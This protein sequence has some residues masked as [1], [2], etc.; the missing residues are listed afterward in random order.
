VVLRGEERPGGVEIAGLHVELGSLGEAVLIAADLGSVRSLTGFQVVANRRVGK[1]ALSAELRRLEG[2]S[3]AGHAR[4]LLLELPGQPFGRRHHVG[5]RCTGATLGPLLL[6]HGSLALAAAARR[7]GDPHQT[8]TGDGGHGS[9]DGFLEGVEMCRDP[10]P[11]GY[12]AN[13]RLEG[14]VDAELR[15]EGTQQ[16]VRPHQQ[17]RRWRPG[18]R[19][20]WARGVRTEWADPWAAY[21]QTGGGM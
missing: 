16:P 3:L 4:R 6:V 21:R 15:C 12:D 5:G 7:D 8:E 10:E 18:E 14:L 2:L 13:P 9:R 17:R 20:W 19:S 11:V 1:S